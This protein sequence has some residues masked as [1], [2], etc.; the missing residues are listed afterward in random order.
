VYKIFAPWDCRDVKAEM[1]SSTIQFGHL[2]FWKNG[3]MARIIPTTITKEKH[4]I[5]PTAIAGL[6]RF[7]QLVHN[8]PELCAEVGDGM[9]G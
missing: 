2:I 7:H 9:K 6:N 4:H 3:G 8:P 5:H 1:A